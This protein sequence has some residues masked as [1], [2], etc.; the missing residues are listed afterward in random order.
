MKRLLGIVHPLTEPAAWVGVLGVLGELL[1]DSATFA[2]FWPLLG[3]LIVR[4]LVAP[5][6][7]RREWPRWRAANLPRG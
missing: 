7:D 6:N 2:D 5:V 4:Q 1:R 3:G